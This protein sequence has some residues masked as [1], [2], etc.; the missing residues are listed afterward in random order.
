MISV[1]KPLR[2]PTDLGANV[3]ARNC[4]YDDLDV[5][6]GKQDQLEGRLQQRY[7]YA[8]DQAAKEV[9]DWYGRQKW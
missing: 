9:N 5:I 1:P 7:G 4:A 6:N 2:F 8:K 3:A